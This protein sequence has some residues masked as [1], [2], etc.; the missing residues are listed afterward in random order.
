MHGELA[1]AQRELEET[2]RTAEQ[3][4][5]AEMLLR[6]LR[7][8]FGPLTTEDEARVRAADTA[9]LDAW[10]ERFIDADHLADVFAETGPY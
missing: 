8:R 10:S 6:L 9:L 7:R 1:R 4:G 5:K 2:R 3:Q